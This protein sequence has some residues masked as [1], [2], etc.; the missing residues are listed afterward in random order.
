MPA[1]AAERLAG[2]VSGPLDM[3]VT[4]AR[5][6][7]ESYEPL[8]VTGVEYQT[9]YVFVYYQSDTVIRLG[10]SSDAGGGV[11]T[12]G[13]ITVVPGRPYRLHI[14]TGA[15]YPPDSILFFKGWKTPDIDSVKSW[16]RIEM[17]GVPVLVTRKPWN[18]PAPG[19]L[20]LGRDARDQTF[21]RR[22]AGTIAAVSR[23]LGPSPFGD[24]AAGGDLRFQIDF[25]DGRLWGNQPLAAMGRTGNADILG[26]AMPDADHFALVYESWGSG[27]WESAPVALPRDRGLALRVR[28]GPSLR[29]DDASPQAIL[30]RTVA[31]WADEKPVWWFRTR[32]ELK[33]GSRLSLVSNEWGS[34]VVEPAFLGRL[35]SASCD[36]APPA[37]R[38]GPMAALELDLAGRGSGVIPVITVGAVGR[39]D[40]VSL[41]WLPGGKARLSYQHLGH[42]PL[43]SAAFAWD[44]AGVHRLRLELPSFRTLDAPNMAPVGQGHLGVDVDGRE[45]R[46]VLL[47]ELAEP[48]LVGLGRLGRE[49]GRSRGRQ[50]A[51]ERALELEI[52]E[53]AF[54][55]RHRLPWPA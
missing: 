26:L 18:D 10:Y 24:M 47:L 6:P 35:E 22:F 54:V 32:Y 19:T 39:S 13:D 50:I 53:A 30:R 14:E 25:P 29:L 27:K 38:S 40:A 7:I 44:A 21:G 55:I 2:T 34:T 1:A 12:S 9:D 8:V 28:L 51:D 5:R 17:D 36:P 20:R 31:I 43:T 48:R 45:E 37:W 16:V 42:P 11:A 23:H 52:G 41:E 33:P 46:G 15:L 3:T 4:F 49:R